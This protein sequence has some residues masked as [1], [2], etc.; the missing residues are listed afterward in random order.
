MNAKKVGKTIAWLRKKNG[1]TKINVFTD[2][3]AAGLNAM[4]ENFEKS[5][6]EIR[7]AKVEAIK[8]AVIKKMEV[9]GSVKRV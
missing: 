6:L 3:C 4:R 1:I 5:Y 2:L 7:N 8:A 9:F